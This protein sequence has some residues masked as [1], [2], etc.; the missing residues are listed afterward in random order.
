MPQ[1]NTR[2]TLSEMRANM[3]VRGAILRR[4]NEKPHLSIGHI[5]GSVAVGATSKVNIENASG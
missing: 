4:I 2:V 5:L 3:P 1:Y